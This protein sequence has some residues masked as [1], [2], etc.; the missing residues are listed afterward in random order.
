MLFC[1][2]DNKINPLCKP[3]NKK[4]IFRLPKA[5]NIFPCLLIQFHHEGD[6]RVNENIGLTSLHTLMMRE[7]NRLARALAQLNPHWN[8]EKLYH[9]ARKIM[10]GYH[11]V[12]HEKHKPRDKCLNK[13][14]QCMF[15]NSDMFSLL[16]Q[17]FF[18]VSGCHLQ[19]LGPPHS[20]PRCHG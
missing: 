11:Q 15:T 13:W 10:G 6:D 17:F 14:R 16:T 2:W 3:S 1:W 20:W 19:R 5:D 9:E 4:Y 7:H 12:R 8:G 18:C